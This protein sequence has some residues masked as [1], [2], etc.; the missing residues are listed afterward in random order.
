MC[1]KL[2]APPGLQLQTSQQQ[3]VNLT[4]RL[5]MSAHMQQAIR[6]L[7]LPL[8]ELEPF[9]EEQVVQNPLL[10]VEGSR[11]DGSRRR[12]RRAK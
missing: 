10:E 6:M 5:I 7:Q 4:Q 9:I 11:D 2:D 12:G 3:Q 1:A 8:M